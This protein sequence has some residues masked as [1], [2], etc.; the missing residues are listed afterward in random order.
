MKETRSGFF[1][2]ILILCLLALVCALP[3][4]VVAETSNSVPGVKY[5]LPDSSDYVLSDGTKVD[6]QF[7]YGDTGMGCFHVKGEVK[8]ATIYNGFA[9]YGV[10]G[11][12]SLHY[13]YTGKFQCVDEDKWYVDNDGTGK[14]NSYGLGL[15]NGVGHGCIIVEKSSDGKDWKKVKDPITNYFTGK[16]SDAESAVYYV[17]DSEVKNGCYYGSGIGSF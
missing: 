6:G 7:F 16:K 10:D 17:P 13:S 15:F 9:A 4:T 8:K 3:V 14:V 1:F 11:P 2:G 12:V 5:V